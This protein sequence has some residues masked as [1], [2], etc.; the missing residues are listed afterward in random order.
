MSCPQLGKDLLN[1]MGPLQQGTDQWMIAELAFT[2]VLYTVYKSDMAEEAQVSVGLGQ[3][4]ILSFGK[5][6]VI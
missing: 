4:Q 3:R 2:V 6:K 1:R 5:R